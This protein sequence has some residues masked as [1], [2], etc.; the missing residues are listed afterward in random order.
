MT[1]RSNILSQLPSPKKKTYE[2]LIYGISI[3]HLFCFG[4]INFIVPQ[5]WLGSGSPTFI[6]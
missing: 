5:L 3:G 2:K 1:N 4:D 6:E